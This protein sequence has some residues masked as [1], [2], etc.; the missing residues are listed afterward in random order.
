MIKGTVYGRKAEFCDETCKGSFK[1]DRDHDLIYPSYN[2]EGVIMSV[3]KAS[4]ACGF[5]AYCGSDTEGE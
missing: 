1:C 2:V 5:C 3:E 4:I